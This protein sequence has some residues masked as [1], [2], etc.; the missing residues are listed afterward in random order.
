MLECFKLG[1]KGA[2]A[3]CDI[4]SGKVSPSGKLPVSILKHQGQCPIYYS[5]RITGKKQF[6][7][8]SYLEMDL[9]PLYEFGYGLSYT[10]F[11]IDVKTLSIGD[12]GITARI[13]V[14]NTGNFAGA[15]V[16][17]LYIKKRYGSISFPDKELKRFEKVFLNIGETK[18]VS[19][20][21]GLGELYYYNSENEYCMEDIC[22]EAMVG[23]S[24]KNIVKRVTSKI[25]SA[26][27]A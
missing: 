17:Q 25:E 11:D 22:L 10:T 4:I 21:I 5:Q 2:K 15:E 14:T 26:E 7:K 13:D 18:T 12:D 20:N 27:R 8:E 3:L 16:I 6:W 23:T 9:S 1:H 19:F 24:S